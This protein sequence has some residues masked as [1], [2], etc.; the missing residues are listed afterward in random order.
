MYASR[1]SWRRGVRTFVF[2]NGSQ[3]EAVLLHGPDA[4]KDTHLYPKL[5]AAY[6]ATGEVER[7]RTALDA[8]FQAETPPWEVPPTPTCGLEPA[9]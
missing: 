1:D 5:E 8:F 9:R 6:S 2:S 3:T 4:L 7:D